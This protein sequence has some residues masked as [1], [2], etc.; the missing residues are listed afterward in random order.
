MGENMNNSLNFAK[1]QRSAAAILTAFFL[2]PS[3]AVPQ[4]P[5]DQGQAPAGAVIKTESRIVLV[6]AV[7]TDKKG[8][9]IHNLTQQDF[10]VYEDNKEQPI[11]SFSSGTDAATQAN[12][13]KRYMI[14]FF[15]NSSLAMPDQIQARSAAAKFVEANASPDHLMA[16]VDFGGTLQVRQ[17]FTSNPELLRASVNSPQASHVASNAPGTGSGQAIAAASTQPALG[18]SGPGGGGGS[19]GSI[20]NV[21]QDFAVRSM[22][23]SVR[24]LARSMRDVPGRKMLILFSAGFPLDPEG[25]SELTATIDACN[26]ANVAVYPVDV[27]GLVAGSNLGPARAHGSSRAVAQL[28][29]PVNSPPIARRADVSSSNPFSR[30]PHLIAA[31]YHVPGPQKPGGGGGS[32]SGSSGGG[33]H[34]SGGGT[35]TGGT[36]GSSGT[37]GGATGTPTA[38]TGQPGGQPVNTNNSI[39]APANQPRTIL[40]NMMQTAPN[41]S[42]NQQVLLALAEGTGGFAVYNTNDLLGGLNKFAREQNEFYVLGYVPQSTPEGAC[43][44]IKVKMIKSGMEVRSRSGYCNVHSVNPLDGKPIEKEME[45]QAAGAQTGAI[46]GALQAPFFYSAPNVARVDVNMEIPG[47]T[48]VFNKDKGKY[49]AVVN[50]LGLAYKPDG[51]VGA[52]FNDVLNIELEKDDWKNF[53]K[54]PYHYQNQ[55]DAVPGDYRLTVVLS[56]GGNNFGKFETPLR[57]EAFDGNKFTIGGVVLST[58]LQKLDEIQTDVDAAILEDRTPLILKGMQV[59]PSASYNFHKADNLVLYSELYEPLLKTDNPPKVAAGYRVFEKASNKQILF[60]GAVPMTEFIQKG[61]PVVPFGLKI[62][63]KDLAPGDYRLVLLAIDG[64]NNQA[65]QR[66]VDFTVA[67]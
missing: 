27:R 38:P 51:S 15:D 52:R 9:Y 32:T 47:D 37:K 41:A 59:N 6:D 33:S 26:K 63:I 46:K 34:P 30:R 58:S 50:V 1:I 49:H 18:S 14:L 23:L 2:V 39:Y 4:A 13:Q 65:P 45:A 56:S 17:N 53:V 5:Q 60:S 25:T 11:S 3:L 29:A 40:P 20:G 22:L 21:E 16:V 36:S 62:P 67:N 12:A 64:A 44:A 7:V 66:T 35:S 55:F 31:S 61:S 48:L 19:F 24:S 57:I 54:L 10:K 8:N 43:H 28:R 42:T